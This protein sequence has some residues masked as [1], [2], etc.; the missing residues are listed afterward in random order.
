MAPPKRTKKSSNTAN[1]P[2]WQTLLHALENATDAQTLGAQSPLAAPYLLGSHVTNSQASAAE[3]GQVLQQILRL[4]AEQ[5]GGKN[6]D[7]Y[8]KLLTEYYLAGHSVQ[9][10]CD[11]IGLGKTT[12]HANRKAAISQL[13][14]ILIGRLQPAIQLEKPAQVATTLVGREAESARCLAAIESGQSLSI[15][16]A[17]GTG[18]TTLARA[19]YH[20]VCGDVD[21]M[22]GFWFT[23]RIGVNDNLQRLLFAI[24]YFFAQHGRPTLWQEAVAN[25]EAIGVDHALNMLR[26]AVAEGE[27]SGQAWLLCFDEVDLLEPADEP[28]HAEIQ[29]LLEGLSD[30]VSVVTVGHQPLFATG[31]SC[32]LEPLSSGAVAQII[33]QTDLAIDRDARA[34]L[35]EITRGNLHLLN[36]VLSI[37]D[38]Q[39]PISSLLGE[40]AQTPTMEFLL[41]YILQRFGEVERGLLMALSVY[42]NYAPLD[43]WPQAEF[44]SALAKVIDYRIAEVD[45]QGGIQILPVYRRVIYANLPEGKRAVLHKQAARAHSQRGAYTVAAYHF[46]Q[47]GETEAAL[48]LWREHKQQEINQGCGGEAFALFSAVDSALL[49]SEGQE[50]LSLIRAELAHLLSKTD[51]AVNTVQSMLQKTPILTVEAKLIGGNVATDQS[52]FG[53]AEA[54]YRESLATAEQLLEA[55]LV[56]IRRGLGAVAYRQRKVDTALREAKLARFEADNL[57]GLIEMM[58]Y[59]YDCAIS[60]YNQ[61]LTLAEELNHTRGIARTSVNLARLHMQLGNFGRAGPYFA[62]AESCYRR[63]GN[64]T[65]E[66][67]V[68]TNRA[69]AY[70]WSGEHSKAIDLLSELDLQAVDSSASS[71][72]QALVAQNFAEAYLGLGNIDEAE[73]W[74]RRAIDFEEGDVLADSYRVLGEILLARG[75]IDEARQYLNLSMETCQSVG[76]PDLYLLGYIWRSMAQ[77]EMHVQNRKQAEEAL[78]T[79]KELFEQV[80]LPNE[81]EKTNQLYEQ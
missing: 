33:A 38:Q 35:Y 62:Q 4:S 69:A 76:E 66:I 80:N 32:L 50:V 19:L 57:E 14:P 2:F 3:R 15:V 42:R 12:F 1:S 36:L 9:A 59:D 56:Q 54:L 29:R 53:R 79:A 44:S 37:Y 72:L 45:A 75:L 30:L 22:N 34:K 16:G 31:A 5:I 48:W 58:R 28:S 52:D 68:K 46:M 71:W 55:G 40:L 24:G 21:E 7:R 61:A 26:H 65:G 78:E 17:S 51:L 39:T 8:Q 81:V 20:Q 13:E 10:V 74:V 41:G 63:I 64:K 77:V 23:F 47:A 25:L 73:R 11:S 27:E 49:T 60:F 6:G 18:K 43:L 70:S 67:G